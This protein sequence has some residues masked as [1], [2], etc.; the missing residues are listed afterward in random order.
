MASVKSMV[1]VVAGNKVSAKSTE[2][3][4][5]MALVVGVILWGGEMIIFSDGFSS[6]TSS[7]KNIST[8]FLP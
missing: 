7:S 5:P 8:R 1:Y 4:F 3:L 2:I 6:E